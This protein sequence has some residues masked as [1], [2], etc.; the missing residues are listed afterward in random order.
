MGYPRERG[1]KRL[2]DSEAKRTWMRE[3]LWTIG[4]KLHRKYDA[5]LVAFLESVADKKQTYIKIALREY[6]AN[7]K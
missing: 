2:P 1:L 5:D 3:N 4:L 7:H 6:I